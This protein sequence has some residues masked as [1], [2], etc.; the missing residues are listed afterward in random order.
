MPTIQIANGYP[1]PLTQEVFLLSFP[2]ISDSDEVLLS[3]GGKTLELRFG[4]RDSAYSN[5]LEVDSD[6]SRTVMMNL[7][8]VP[9]E[10]RFLDFAVRP[11]VNGAQSWILTDYNDEAS[12]WVNQGAR[13]L[14]GIP[15]TI[16]RFS[17][18][19]DFWSIEALEETNVKLPSV[20]ANPIEREPEPTVVTNEV[21]STSAVLVTDPDDTIFEAHEPVAPSAPAPLQNTPV[22]GLPEHLKEDGQN[23]R[24][25]GQA[26]EAKNFELIFDVSASMHDNLRDPEGLLPVVY[27]IQA[28]AASVTPK[29]ITISM[30]AQSERQVTQ[31]DDVL[32]VLT[33]EA[34][35]ALG[36]EI[37]TSDALEDL[38]EDRIAE[39]EANTAI[40]VV[41]D[42]F[43][44]LEPDDLIPLLESGR[45][46]MRI[47]LLD[48]PTVKVEIGESK[49]LQWQ[50]IDTKAATSV[51]AQ[52]KSLL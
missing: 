13:T 23:A 50:Q 9:Q 12:I 16:A 15:T 17:R 32:A 7:A 44:Y 8:D 27:A 48:T 45:K 22:Y 39:L 47:L 18:S 42:A 4:A 30:G 37:Q 21:N 3:L 51:L 24:S 49:R 35:R 38:L 52:I 33:D 34:N 10:L 40:F 25:L 36:I 31:T 1:Q 46:Q 11:W 28:L 26:G 19:G 5:F 14:S 41:S 20:S 43:P 29:P 6:P 2:G